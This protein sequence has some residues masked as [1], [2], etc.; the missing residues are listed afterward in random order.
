MN[1]ISK[2][3]RNLLQAKTKL[4]TL[5]LAILEDVTD[6]VVRKKLSALLDDARAHLREVRIE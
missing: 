4:S 3:K 5:G 6:P 1:T 2:E